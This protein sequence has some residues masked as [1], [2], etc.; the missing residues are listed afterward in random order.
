[1]DGGAEFVAPRVAGRVLGVSSNTLRRYAQRGKIKYI[2]TN[3][4]Q[5]RYNVVSYK[6]YNLSET[7]TSPSHFSKR[8]HIVYCRVSSR[9]QVD[10]L[11]RQTAA[12]Q[13]K[14]PDH[15]IVT[16]VGSRINYKRK[17]LL[18]ILE[19]VIKGQVE[20]VV[21]AHKDR[22]ARFGTELIEWICKQNDTHLVILCENSATQEEELANDLM[23][24]VHVFSCRANGKRRYK[25]HEKG[26]KPSQK[27]V[28][29]V[30][31]RSRKTGTS[32]DIRTDEGRCDKEPTCPPTTHPSATINVRD[33]V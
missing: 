5:Y 11:E 20:E 16:D 24:I 18:R 29:R 32:A 8:R 1:M 2:V 26:K 12:M 13:A 31:D 33:V 30:Q 4:G 21:V 28:R 9:K 27:R 6:C 23:A 15:E 14:Y 7:S 22:L 19:A 10:D 25:S 17:G 3:G